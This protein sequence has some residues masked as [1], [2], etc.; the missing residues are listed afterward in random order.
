[1]PPS[2]VCGSPWIYQRTITDAWSLWLSS[3]ASQWEVDSV[4]DAAVAEFAPILHGETHGAA[5]N[6]LVIL[7][8]MHRFRVPV[9]ALEWPPERER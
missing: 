5:E 7:T 1:M 8:L 3:S 9:L 4:C 2:L 6:P